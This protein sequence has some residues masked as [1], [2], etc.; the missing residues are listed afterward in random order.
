M[1]YLHIFNVKVSNN[2][3]YLEKCA[4]GVKIRDLKIGFET[5]GTWS[6]VHCSPM[7]CEC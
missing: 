5:R 1:Q 6:C 7:T 3:K 2:K 4:L